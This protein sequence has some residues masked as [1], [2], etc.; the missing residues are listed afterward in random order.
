MSQEGV[1][2]NNDSIKAELSEKKSMFYR[3]LEKYELLAEFA[4]EL[5][6]KYPD[7]LDYDMFHFLVGS[8]PMPDRM[9]TKFDFPGEDSI[10]GF[11]RGV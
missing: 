2:N 10:E 5:K 7:Y 9:P 11:L 3:D 1:P 4:K 6:V 8:T